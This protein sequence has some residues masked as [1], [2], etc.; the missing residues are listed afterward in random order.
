VDLFRSWR[1]RRAARQYAR[2]LSPHL[3]Y[4]YGAAEHYSVQQIATAAVRL[5]LDKDFI[6][7]GLAAFLSAE[8]FAAMAPQMPVF[9]P[10]EEARTLVERFRPPDFRDDA[11][12]Y[13]SNRGITG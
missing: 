8:D 7:L 3:R 6:A 2:L 5:G 10:Y 13:E 4:A 1:T 11:G 12:Y 9:I